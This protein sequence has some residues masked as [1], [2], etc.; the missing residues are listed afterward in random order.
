M[1]RKLGLVGAAMLIGMAAPAWG[2]NASESD[3]Q[4]AHDLEARFMAA[5]NQQNAD[6]VASLFT[7]DGIRVTPQGILQGRDAIRKDLENRFKAKAHDISLE[8]KTIRASENG[9]WEAGDW[10]MKIGDH[11]VHGYYLVNLTREGDGFRFRYDAF[12]VAPPAPGQQA[13]PQR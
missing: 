6:E 3:R 7:E 2:Q 4:S 11:L 5:F 13:Q 1:K 12:N 9:V 8:A 10:T